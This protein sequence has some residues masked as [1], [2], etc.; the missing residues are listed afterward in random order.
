MTLAKHAAE[1]VQNIRAF[2]YPSDNTSEPL[3]INALVQEAVLLIRNKLERRRTRV[4]L[5]LTRHLPPVEGSFVQLEQVLVNLMMNGIEAMKD[6]DA[7]ERELRVSTLANSGREIEV[8]VMDRGVGILPETQGRIF[9]TFFTTKREGL[10]M[11]LPICRT[12]TEAHG[13]R[14][15]LTRNP[16]SGVTFHLALPAPGKESG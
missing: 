3:D 8:T 1:I 4:T 9:D 7:G 6:I 11:G 13:G 15:W 16:A 12:I 2:L 10:G 14:L 5:K